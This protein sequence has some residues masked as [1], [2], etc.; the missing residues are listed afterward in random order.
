MNTF[1]DDLPS[2]SLQPQIVIPT[3][4]CENSKATIDNMF[5]NMHNPLV[6][7]AI[8]G[9]ISSSISDHL[10][11]FLYYQISFPVLYQLNITFCIMIW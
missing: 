9:N 11:Q 8:S 2:D 3:R 7:T 6:K 10:L 1:F 5:C 4:V